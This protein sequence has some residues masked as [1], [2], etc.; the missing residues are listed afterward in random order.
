MRQ[1]CV[2]RRR[3]AARILYP[4][5]QLKAHWHK[6]TVRPSDGERGH[7]RVEFQRARGRKDWEMLS[8]I[9]GLLLVSEGIGERRTGH[10]G[11]D[12]SSPFD[13]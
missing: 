6:A 9:Q 4:V 13:C 7:L 12:S 5:T 1:P 11:L 8:R 2:V 3:S 10:G